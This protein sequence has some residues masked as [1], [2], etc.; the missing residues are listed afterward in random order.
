MPEQFDPF[1]PEDVSRPPRVSGLKV[2]GAV[3]AVAVMPLAVVVGHLPD[4]PEATSATVVPA[5]DLAA[6]SFAPAWLAVQT[7]ATSQITLNTVA[8]QQGAAQTLAPAANCGVNLGTAASQLLTLKG[9]TGGAASASLASY[10]SGSIGVKEKKSGTSCYQVGATSE[11]L[12]LG[13]GQGLST[14]LGADAVAT[15]AYLDLELKGSARILATA[16][17]GGS[18]VGTYELQ[19]G[20]SIGTPPVADHPPFECNSPSDSGPDSGV[21]DNCRWPVSAPSWTGADDG[22]FFDTLTLKALVGSFSLEGGADGAVQP[23]APVPT[24]NASILEIAADTI[25]CGDTSKPATGDGSAPQVTVY[26]LGNA[27]TTEPCRAVPYSISNGPQFAQFLKPLD[28]QTSAQFIWNL[29]WKL[30]V[31]AGT[32]A[33]PDL[34]IDYEYPAGDPTPEITALGWCPDATYGTDGQF[35]GYTGQ[36][37][38]ALDQE[39][40]LAGTQ[41]ACVISREGVSSDGVPSS[42]S[43]FVTDNDK[44][45]VYGDAKMQ[46]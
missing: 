11:S 7:G 14:T 29:T 45:Y 36:L 13:L 46:W 40:D 24:P 3:L 18:V 41:Y 31:S 28:V 30:P 15:S 25:G 1:H 26:R 8:G 17:L 12:E 9:S 4:R 20:S 19:S 35:L 39:P 2:A 16:R 37:P 22:V 38:A 23:A 5:A 43:D 10:A 6:P 34:K 32:T 33:L 21:N 27:D 44:V 42:A